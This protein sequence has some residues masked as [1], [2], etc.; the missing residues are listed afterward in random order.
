RRS[1][2]AVLTW[3]RTALPPGGRKLPGRQHQRRR[4]TNWRPSRRSALMRGTREGDTMEERRSAGRE[5][6]FGAW[7]RYQAAAVGFRNYWYPVMFSSQ[8]GDKPRS[9]TLLGEKICLVRHN[10]RAYAL[11]DRCPH[12]GVP[13][14]YGRREFPGTIT[15]AYHAWT[16][17]VTNGRLVGV[18][19]DG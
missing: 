7:P 10:G 11:H 3:R 16:Y 12:R 5:D 2:R 9:I 15:C 14:S 18:L 19:T 4:R 1:D 17:D 6:M 13:L 8:L